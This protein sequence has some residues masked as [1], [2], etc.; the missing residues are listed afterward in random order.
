MH[1]RVPSLLNNSVRALGKIS[2]CKECADVG[3]FEVLQ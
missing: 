3:F 2:N 1:K